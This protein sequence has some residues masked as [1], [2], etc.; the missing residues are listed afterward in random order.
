[1]DD[2]HFTI[3]VLHSSKLMQRNT[4]ISSHFAVRKFLF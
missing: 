2:Y 4:S 1:M 3:S